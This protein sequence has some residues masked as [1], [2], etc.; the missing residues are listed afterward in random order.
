LVRIIVLTYMYKM[1]KQILA[2]L[3]IVLL[4]SVC[5][6]QQDPKK[7]S[8]GKVENSGNPG[9]KK[10]KDG[11]TDKIDASDQ[12]QPMNKSGAKKSTNKDKATLSK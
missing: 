2:G 11:T 1:K 6:A 9:H 10:N 5:Q 8:E 3:A 7:K 12:S 4:T